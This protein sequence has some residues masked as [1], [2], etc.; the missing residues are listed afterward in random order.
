MM[1]Y[2]KF[3]YFKKQNK[4]TRH[5]FKLLQFKFIIRLFCKNLGLFFMIIYLNFNKKQTPDAMVRFYITLFKLELDHA[6]K[7]QRYFL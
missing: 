7:F 5:V 4:A 3:F 1:I 2:F 6:I